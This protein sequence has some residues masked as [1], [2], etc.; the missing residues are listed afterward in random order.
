[1]VVTVRYICL[2]VLLAVLAP[3]T[4]S[5][6]GCTRVSDFFNAVYKNVVCQI[7]LL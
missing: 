7:P 1:M 3:V 6:H 4:T 2:Q 5:K